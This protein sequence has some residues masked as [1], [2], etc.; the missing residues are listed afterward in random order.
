LPPD[1]ARAWADALRALLADEAR[2]AELRAR[3]LAQARKFSWTR[4]AE[5]TLAVYESVRRET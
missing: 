5:E 4:C 3:G 1:D 2:R